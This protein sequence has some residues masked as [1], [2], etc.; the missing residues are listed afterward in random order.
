MTANDETLVREGR[1]P[2]LDGATAWINSEPLTPAAVRGSVVLV[3]IWTYTCINWLRTL[4][5]VRAWSERYREHGLV[6]IGV[7]S[8]EFSF[9]HDLENVRRATRQMA[10]GYP[11]A[12]DSDFAIWNALD[13]RY[14]PAAYFVDAEGSIR[15]H[16]FGEGRYEESERLIQ[17]L[18]R[19]SGRTG[20]DD[21]PVSV[22]GSGAEAPADWGSLE[23][24][25]TYVGYRQA[26][27]FASP[28]GAAF[29]VH[30]SYAVPERLRVGQ[31]ALSGDW[32]VARE[33]ARSNEPGGAIALRFHARDLH[34]V[35]GPAE[36]GAAVAFQVTIDGEPPGDAAGADVGADGRGTVSDHRLYQLVRQPGHVGDRTF[37]IAFAEPGVEAYV[38]TFG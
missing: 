36:R 15:G 33:A 11:V 23:T 1:L 37:E 9:E 12:V 16:H 3:Q 14:W 27:G 5:Y 7:H 22:V 10:I 21:D 6:V 18:L 25:E 17:Q 8:P 20:F 19:E 2:A 34:L 26:E 29:D 35:L 24:G 13:N 28:G 31:W 38:F 30:R 4:P 32:T